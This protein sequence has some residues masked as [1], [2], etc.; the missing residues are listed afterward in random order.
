MTA[1]LVKL[2]FDEFAERNLRALVFCTAFQ[3]LACGSESRAFFETIH[4]QCDKAAH[5]LGRQCTEVLRGNERDIV[6]IAGRLKYVGRALTALK[7]YL[8]ESSPGLQRQ[9]WALSKAAFAAIEVQSI[10]VV[11]DATAEAA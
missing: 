2:P 8:G 3:E 11:L 1:C 10:G 9:C 5:E 4:A 6:E 7:Q